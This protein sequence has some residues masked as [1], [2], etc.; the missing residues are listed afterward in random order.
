[1]TTAAIHTA[2]TG[3][4]TGEPYMLPQ[5]ILWQDLDDFVLVND[6]EMWAAMRLYLE[7][8]KTLAEPAGAATLAAALRYPDLWRG[9][10]TALI[11]SGGN[12]SL[13]ELRAMTA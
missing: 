2:A 3:L 7:K 11:P 10:K 13:D 8:A 6:A 12:A 4:A 1:P 5:H 9:K